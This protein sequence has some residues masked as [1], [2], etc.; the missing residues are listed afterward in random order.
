MSRVGARPECLRTT[1]ERGFVL[2]DRFY[3]TACP[4]P[5]PAP[6][7]NRDPNRAQHA[8]DQPAG[9]A[10]PAHPDRPN[11]SGHPPERL[12][13]RNDHPAVA[14][15]RQNPGDW[16]DPKRRVLTRQLCRRC[17][18]RRDCTELAL[19]NKPS[20]GMWAG[21][22]LD[23]DFDAKQHLL[24]LNTPPVPNTDNGAPTQPPAPVEER[25]RRRVGRQTRVRRL[26]LNSLPPAVAALIT[27]RASGHCEIMAP[28]CT[29]QQTAIFTRRRH[30]VAGSDLASPADGIAACHN[31]I[32]L[33]EDSA[34]PTAL[35]LGYLVD[36]RCTTSTTAML[37][38]QQRWVYLDI[39]GHIHD[40][41]DATLT[42]SAS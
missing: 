24:V 27:A 25:P 31:C 12:T 29:Y 17:P 33:I 36:P 18:V 34:I 40:I 35:D 28:A 5:V 26:L 6:F 2:T 3:G 15:C 23:N 19:R 38:R 11:H 4:H 1:P 9:P 7:A 20:Y 22:W 30:T 13:D 42:H 41:N 21:I 10:R 39:R 37:W 16:S 14:L 32:N 8:T